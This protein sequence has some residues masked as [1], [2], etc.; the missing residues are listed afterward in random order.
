VVSTQAWIVRC[1]ACCAGATAPPTESTRTANPA[2]TKKR[3]IS[4]P[5]SRRSVRPKA[6]CRSVIPPRFSLVNAELVASAEGLE[7]VMFASATTRGV[8]A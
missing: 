6:T 7:R 3:S 5:S 1:D 2:T 4:A 8:L